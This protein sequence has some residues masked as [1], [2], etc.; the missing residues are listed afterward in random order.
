MHMKSWSM[1]INSDEATLED[2]PPALVR[3]LMPAKASQKNPLR[4]PAPKVVEK[5]PEPPTPILPN[6]HHGHLYQPFTPL[7]YYPYG[8]PYPP[9]TYPH[10]HERS[11]PSPPRRRVELQASSPVRFEAD[12][13]SDKLAEYFDWLVRGYPGKAQQIRE[14]LSTLKGEEIVFATLND[15][16][17][18]LW[19]DWKVSNGLILLVKGHMKKWE[20]EQARGRN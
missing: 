18:E 2:C 3:I 13:N 16:P 8:P 14:C 4:N 9:P 12:Q 11:P 10:R 6:T 20:R 1:A 5:P 7:P 15:I 19:R 17:S